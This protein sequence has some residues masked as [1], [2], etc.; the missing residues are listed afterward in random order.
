MIPEVL[1]ICFIMLNEIKLRLLGLYVEI[2]E[3]IESVQDGIDRNL[4]K[5]DE[6]KVKLKRL[7][8]SNMCMKMHFIPLKEQIISRQEGVE[9]LKSE[10]R[11]D[12][13]E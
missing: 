10:L 4:E 3:D 5:G 6:E 11:Q 1:I 12:I 8:S 7:E 9:H 13:E 2:E